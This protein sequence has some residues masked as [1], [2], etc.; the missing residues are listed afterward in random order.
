MSAQDPIKVYDARWEEHE[1]DDDQVRRLFEAAFAYGRELN[2]DTAVLARDGRLAAG[3]VLEL[4][5]EAAV[6]MG[7]RTYLCAE[8][9]GTPHGYFLTHHVSLQHPRT[10]GAMITASH[11]PRQYIGAKFVMPGMQAVGLNCGPMGGLA[12]VREHYHAADRPAPAAGGCLK[13]I[14]LTREF[15]EFSIGQSGLC[16]GELSGLRVVVD[17]MHGSAGPEMVLALQQAGAE[18][19]PLR[20]V[21]DGRFPTG[22]PNPTSRG[23][24]DAAVR[25]AA[26]TGCRAVVGLDG[27][28]D[29]LVLGDGR[30]ILSAGFAAVAVL[31]ACGLGRAAK[32]RPVLYDPKV[33]PPALAQWRRL[34][35]VPIL[36]RNGHSQIK[37]YM[38]RLDALAAAEESGHYYHRITLGDLTA[39]YENSILT[40][41]LFA[42]SI[43]RDP[44]LMDRLWAL[45]NRVLSTGEFNCQFADDDTR[46]RA[47]AELIR[48]LSAQGAGTVRATDDGIDLEGTVVSR[49]VRL[50]GDEA[51]LEPG[52]Y[53][54]YLRIATNEKA[55]ARSYF[56]AAD[57]AV[58]EAVQEQVRRTWLSNFGGRVVE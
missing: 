15:I 52:W 39:W 20:I 42:A 4:A 48:Q 6:R 25:L 30:G 2:A 27:D 33:S 7:L 56:S 9:I 49:G 46:D 41:L 5:A 11:N 47:L 34:N 57:P 50:A 43:R 58:L 55:V 38:R 10:I 13:L 51:V 17:G 54:G 22:S 28:G 44:G 37:D 1:F 18:V 32:P 36:F 14:D 40:T 3:H 24:M 35:A 31:E 19:E 21:P 26:E 29:R 23:K 16:P 45:Q 12:R 53:S 8:P